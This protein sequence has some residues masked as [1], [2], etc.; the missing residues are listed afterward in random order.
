MKKSIHFIGIGGIG[1]SAIAK[2]MLMQGHHISGSDIKESKVTHELNSLGAKI[3]IGHNTDNVGDADLVTYSSAIR[4]DNPE[5]VAAIQKNIPIKKRAELLAQLMKD[6]KS[7]TVAGAHGKT[8]TTSLASFLLE[9]ANFNPTVVTG[10]N[11]FNFNSNALLGKGSYFVAELDESD[12]SFLYFNPLYSI[13]TNIDL[14]HI[15]YYHNLDNILMAFDRFFEQTQKDGIIFACGDDKNIMK[16]LVPKG[17]RY[18]T[19]GLTKDCDIFADNISLG[20]F[21]SRFNCNYKKRSLGEISLNIPGRHNISNSLAVIALAIELGIEW[22]KIEEII[23]LYKGV[24]RRFQL[25]G[26]VNGVRVVDDYGHHPTEIRATLEA[27]K[28]LNPKRLIVAFQPHRFSRTKFLLDEFVNCFDLVD[29]LIITDIYSA[30]EDFMPG[31]SSESLCSKLKQKNKKEVY[32]LPKQDITKRIVDIKNPGDV[33][34]TLGAGDIGKLSDEILEQ[35][36]K[37]S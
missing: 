9:K 16:I 34:I 12:G 28:S 3:F 13:V 26:E 31:V 7:I 32:Y 8:T 2:I 33:V 4:Q 18:V 24:E 10:G 22:N 11:V 5:L 17:K 36:K 15:D 29:Y 25:K 20:N 37:N 21:S 1:M 27:A 23:G 14:E 30:N 19:F 35:L 6:K